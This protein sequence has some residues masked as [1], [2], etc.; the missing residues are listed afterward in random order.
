MKGLFTEIFTYH[1]HMNQLVIDE[2]RKHAAHLPSRTIPLFCHVINAHQI[3]N[4]RILGEQTFDTWAV[5][6]T[7]ALGTLDND[8]FIN[9]SRILE[10]DDFERE[11]VYRTFKGVEYTNTVRDI[12]FH[13]A[14]HTTHHRGQIIGDFRANNITPVVTDYIF[15]KR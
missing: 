11:V 1:N 8:N 5:H 10:H 2:L 7:A 6:A 3:W 13:I 15:Y 9:T 14:N 12:L 4:A